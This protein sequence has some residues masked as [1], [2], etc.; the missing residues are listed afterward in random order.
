MEDKALAGQLEQLIREYL[1]VKCLDLVELIVR[2]QGNRLVVG[3]LADKPLGGIT[4]GECTDLNRG[5]GSLL[6]ER[7]IMQGPYVLEVSSPGLDRCLKT[8]RDFSRCLNRQVKFFL[9]EPINGTM[10]LA[11]LVQEAFDDAV[12]ILTEQGIIR[13]PYARVTK[14]KQLI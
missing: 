10:E 7:E 12:D 9:A 11:G 3:I 2:R 14:A 1:E 13:I 6:E 4:L 8:K 5:I